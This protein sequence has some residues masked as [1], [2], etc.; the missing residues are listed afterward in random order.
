MLND[1]LMCSTKTV[2]RWKFIS[3]T[4][5]L[6]AAL[7]RGPDEQM[8]CTYKL[9]AVVVHLG[10]QAVGSSGGHYI[11]YVRDD[12]THMWLQTD[13]LVVKHSILYLLTVLTDGYLFVY[14]RSGLFMYRQEMEEAD[15][16]PKQTTTPCALYKTV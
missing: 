7:A 6:R 4:L 8:C 15:L 11:A 3:E 9:H 13:D 1:S 5:D 14:V 16:T 10:D 2:R 12:R